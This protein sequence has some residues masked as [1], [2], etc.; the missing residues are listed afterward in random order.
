M[1]SKFAK[2]YND[3]NLTKN[4]KLNRKNSLNIS[5]SRLERNSC[6]SEDIQNNK[7][8]P[9]AP[10]QQENNEYDINKSISGIH[11]VEDPSMFESEEDLLANHLQMPPRRSRT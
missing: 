5:K 3:D 8:L 10:Q 9:P 6:T 4:H 2:N 7:P 1:T 11:E